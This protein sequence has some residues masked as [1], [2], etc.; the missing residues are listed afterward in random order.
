MAGYAFKT[1]LFGLESAEQRMEDSDGH[2]M[3]FAQWLQTKLEQRG[4]TV[5]TL[6]PDTCGWRMLLQLEPFELYIACFVTEAGDASNFEMLNMEKHEAVWQ[7]YART[8][9]PLFKSL[10]KKIDDAPAETKLDEELKAIL[11]GEPLV[12]FVTEPEF[13]HSG[14]E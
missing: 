12:H 4:Y 7:C 13:D 9:K 2:G 11:S 3:E 6:K 5:H 1:E 10:F 8:S 14:G